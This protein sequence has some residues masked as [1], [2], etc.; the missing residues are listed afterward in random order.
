M[1]GSRGRGERTPELRD[2]S[3]LVGNEEAAMARS[4]VLV[5]WSILSCSL[6]LGCASQ[7]AITPGLANAPP[8]GG[9]GGVDEGQVDVVSNGRDSCESVSGRSPLRGHVPPC[10]TVSRPA[11]TLPPPAVAMAHQQSFVVPWLDHFYV[12]WPCTRSLTSLEALQAGAV[13]LS[14]STPLTPGE[15]TCASSEPPR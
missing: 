14:S 9:A 6:S 11:S 12:G 4:P 13:A 2:P 3:K 15:G 7:S 1:E 10:P 5:G 8:L